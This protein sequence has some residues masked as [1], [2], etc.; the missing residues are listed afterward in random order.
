[1]KMY[2]KIVKSNTFTFV[3]REAEEAY[4]LEQI[5]RELTVLTKTCRVIGRK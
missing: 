4:Q 3:R 2:H 5:L 1:M